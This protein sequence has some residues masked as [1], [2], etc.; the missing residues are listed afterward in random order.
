MAS[1]E[2]EPMESDSGQLIF[3]IHEKKC[4]S[5]SKNTKEKRNVDGDV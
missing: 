3:A 2:V 1:V 5:N 4:L